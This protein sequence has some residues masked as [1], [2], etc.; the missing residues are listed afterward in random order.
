MLVAM[1]AGGDAVVPWCCN[2]LKVNKFGALADELQG[3]CACTLIGIADPPSFGD[4]GWR[5]LD[6]GS[7]EEGDERRLG[8]TS[9]DEGLDGCVE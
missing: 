2:E 8:R 5:G 3:C 1:C 7:E 4:G 9:T 6:S